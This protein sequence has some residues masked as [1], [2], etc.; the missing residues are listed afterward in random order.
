VFA[1]ASKDR[2][3]FDGKLEFE[4]TVVAHRG[5]DSWVEPTLGK[6]KECL[7]SDVPPPA[8]DTCEYC[9]YI[10]RAKSIWL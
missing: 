9:Q 4:V 6:M 3:A 2:R 5:N 8:G 1:N 7:E 10:E